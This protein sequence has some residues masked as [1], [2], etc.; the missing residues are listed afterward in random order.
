MEVGGENNSAAY[1]NGQL[2]LGYI[3]AKCKANG[4]FSCYSSGTVLAL[5]VV[6]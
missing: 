4:V 3:I 6:S 1:K 2:D 5:L